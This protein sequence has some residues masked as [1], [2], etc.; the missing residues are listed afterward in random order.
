MIFITQPDNPSG[1]LDH[2]IYILNLEDITPANGVRVYADVYIWRGNQTRPAAI[3]TLSKVEDANRNV[4]F[5][6]S[7]IARSFLH[8]E[9][10]ETYTDPTT[11]VQSQEDTAW[12][13]VEFYHYATPPALINS[14]IVLINRGIGS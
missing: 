12:I 3:A 9:N 5:D 13:Q 1:A 2:L 10:P 8:V 7:H 4:S 14:N 11:A 6:L